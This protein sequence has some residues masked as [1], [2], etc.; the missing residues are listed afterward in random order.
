VPTGAT[1]GNVVVTV[2]GVASNAVSFTVTTTPGPSISTLNPTSGLVGTST[3]ISGANVGVPER[4]STVKFNGV[5]ATPKR[6]NATSIVA[7]VPTGATTGSVVV[8]VGGVASNG[9]SFTV[10]SSDTT[11]PTVSV[12]APSSGATVSG[13]VTLSANASDNVGV[14]SVQFQIDGSNFGAADTASPYT[15]SWNTT[16]AANGTHS[17]TAIAKD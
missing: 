7:P 2:G 16:T 9:V 8:T 15:T 14:A 5:A 3:T 17:I 6:G 12:T 4:T 1:T 11:P 10:T 13:T